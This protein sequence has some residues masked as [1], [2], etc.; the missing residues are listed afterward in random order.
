MKDTLKPGLDYTLRFTVPE[1]K[2]VPHLYPES[3]IFTSMPRVLATGFMVGLMEWA[4]IELLR[5]HLDE[6]EGS[7]GVEIS[8]SHVAATPPGMTVEVHATCTAV[9]GRRLAFEV[10]ARD[11]AEVIGQGTHR[12]HVVEWA[13]FNRRLADKAALAGNAASG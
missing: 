2:T 5:T 3:D 8:V 6:G 9:D 12:R 13:R 11:D 4:C 7:L 10:V 1:S